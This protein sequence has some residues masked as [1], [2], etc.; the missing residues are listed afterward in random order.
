MTC[1]TEDERTLLEE[2]LAWLNAELPVAIP[3]SRVTV[4]LKTREAVKEWGKQG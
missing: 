2:F 3:V 1:R 4:Y